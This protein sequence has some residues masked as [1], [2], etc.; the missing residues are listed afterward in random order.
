MAIKAIEFHPEAV[1]EAEAALRW[2][3][4]QSLRAAEA[5]FRELEK[6]VLV[7][8]EAPDRWPVFIGGTRRFLLHRFPFSLIYR[9]QGDGLQIV[10]VAHVRRRP[11]YGR[12]R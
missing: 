6:A 9:P 10:A 1:H 7:I 11:G 8:A 4:T 2:Y 3:R 12:T 5:F